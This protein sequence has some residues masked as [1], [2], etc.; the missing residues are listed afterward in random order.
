MPIPRQRR[1]VIFPLLLLG[2]LSYFLYE[3]IPT[4]AALHSLGD[5]TCSNLQSVPTAF[6][7]GNHIT[8]EKPQSKVWRH[9]DRWWGIFPTS[10][11]GAAS[12]GTWLWRLDHV[13]WTSVLKLDDGT[14]VQADVKVAGNL[15]HALLYDDAPRL[16]SAEYVNGSYQPWSVR[17][18]PVALTSGD[19]TGVIELDSTG[20]MWY[21][22]DTPSAIVAYYSDTPYTSWNG[23]VTV[24]DGITADDIG[25]VVALPNQQI[26]V[27]WSNQ[28]SSLFGYKSHNDNADPTLWSA[29][30]VADT[31]SNIADD[32]LNLAVAGDGTLYAAV[33]TSTDL[34]K[35]LVRTP[36]GIWQGH[37]VDESG[38]GTRPIVLM[39]G[40]GDRVT[41]IYTSA[42][43][44][45]PIV[46]KESA[47]QTI[48]FGP[49]LTLR[50]GGFN[51]VS[52]TKQS[53]SDQLVVLFTDYSNI[54][55][56]FCSGQGNNPTPTATAVAVATETP[57]PT[58][59]ATEEIPSETATAT[60]VVTPSQ[61]ATVEATLTATP[62]IDATATPSATVA[63]STATPTA[64]ATTVAN[65]TATPTATPTTS[66]IL[67]EVGGTAV[68]NI[69][70]LFIQVTFPPGALTVPAQVKI[71]LA[72]IRRSIQPPL[73]LLGEPFV[74]SVTDMVGEP[75][76]TFAEPVTVQILYSNTIPQWDKAQARTQ[77]VE[78]PSLYQWVAEEERWEA[79]PT[80]VDETK[81]L[82]RATITEPGTFALL[83]LLYQQYLPLIQQ[84]SVE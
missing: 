31:G 21:V 54:D 28:N 12:A 72:G 10:S 39:D 27:L 8:G 38:V 33:K 18:T 66:V 24:A 35:L 80:S 83:R 79:L 76:T 78:P 1:Q 74:L 36:A 41:V 63:T 6:G 32:H 4:H 7:N 34:I 69:D 49:R 17:T 47:H 67:P 3:A 55:G 57:T 53:Y 82:A 81:S 23:P 26:G 59:T 56:I 51:D 40:Q 14:D 11:A 5:F 71:S 62:P 19:E 75:L 13:T 25:G 65:E 37:Q 44:L 70:S 68:Q 30:E 29:E 46:Y 50:D 64:T 84:Q 45:N 2:I 15:I 16:V 60:P 43:G 77:V 52:S 20:R 9:D 42:N 61:T 58:A 73:H 22:T 48:S